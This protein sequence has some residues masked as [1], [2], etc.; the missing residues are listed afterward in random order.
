MISLLGLK[1]ENGV[2]V[3]FYSLALGGSVYYSFSNEIFKKKLK[4]DVFYKVQNL[5]NGKFFISQSVLSFILLLT[6]PI[7]K[8]PVATSLLV[9]STILQ[10]INCFFNINRKVLLFFENKRK[11]SENCNREDKIKCPSKHCSLE[12]TSLILNHLYAGTIFF[13]GVYLYNKLK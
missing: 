1:P 9:C 11:R 5:L 3:F 6:T 4:S 7:I 10:S 12:T 2:H 13:Y 8:Y